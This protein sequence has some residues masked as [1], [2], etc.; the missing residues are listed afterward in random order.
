MDTATENFVRVDGWVTPR[1]ERILRRAVEISTEHGYNYLGVEHL[2]LAIA[3]DPQSLPISV[4]QEPLT[5]DEWRTAITAA[6]PGLP[7]GT[8]AQSDPLTVTVARN[9]PNYQN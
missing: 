4:W 8:S 3:E 1:L 2:A 6:L 5:A 9:D 7:V